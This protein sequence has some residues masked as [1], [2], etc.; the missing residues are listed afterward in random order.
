MDICNNFTI[1]G[2]DLPLKT[3]INEIYLGQD[4]EKI[5][6]TDDSCIFNNKSLLNFTGMCQCKINSNSIDYLLTEYEL[7]NYNKELLH[8][9]S[10]IKDSLDIFRCV[11][12]GFNRNSFKNNP[13]FNTSLIMII[14]Q[15]ISLLWLFCSTSDTLLST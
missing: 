6:C 3:R 13:G 8:N 11:E 7:S 5:I 12:K 2:I 10:K 14:I 1:S 4:T 15:I 9:S